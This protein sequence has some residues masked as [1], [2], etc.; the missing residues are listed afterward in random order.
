[1]LTCIV[2]PHFDHLEQFKKILPN[3]L[4]Q[5]FPL[6]I[7]DDASPGEC[8]KNLSNLLEKLAPQSILIRHSENQGK[9]GAVMTGLRTAK[10]AGF[11]HAL[12]IDADGQHDLGSIK[13]LVE[14]A[15]VYPHNMICG[16]PVFDESISKLRYYSRYITL[17]LVWLETLSKEIRDALCGLR[18]YPLNETMKLVNGE[19]KGTRMA[20]DPEILVRAVWAGIPLNYVPVKI[21]YPEDGKSH[22]HYLGDNL[23]IAWMHTR[24]IAGMLIR[25]TRLIWRKI[26]P[27][28]SPTNN[29]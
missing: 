14:R 5:G 23:E 7:V 9:G 8:F 6:V 3:L 12:Q 24:L 13:M 2:I 28:K 26:Y 10:E 16:Q 15:E 25:S 29:G 11:T 27:G 20:F 17:Y 18:L 1:M 19:V 4:E 21:V 22:F